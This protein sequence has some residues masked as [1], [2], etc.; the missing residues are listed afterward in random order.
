MTYFMT[1]SPLHR[2]KLQLQ[3]PSYGS[4]IHDDDQSP[5]LLGSSRDNYAVSRGSLFLYSFKYNP[6]PL[7]ETAIGYAQLDVN[8]SSTSN[9]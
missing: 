9:T 2:I 7:G 6:K 3:I 8:Q 4:A 5:T 1:Y